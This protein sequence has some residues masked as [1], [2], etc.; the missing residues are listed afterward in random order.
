VNL[1]SFVYKLKI[2]L[3]FSIIFLIGSSRLDASSENLES[4]AGNPQKQKATEE[5]FS[6]SLNP[7]KQSP[8][9]DSEYIAAISLLK[10][11]QYHEA[12]PLL[13]KALQKS[14]ANIF[15]KADYLLCLVWTGSYEKASLF[16]LQNEKEL[17]GVNYVP[18]HV[19]RVFFETAQYTKAKRLYEEALRTNPSDVEAL[20]GLIFSSC[21]LRE[22]DQ[23]HALIENHSKQK[24]IPPDTASFL[25]AYTLQQEGKN[26]EAYALYAQLFLAV[27]DEGLLK[28]IQDRRK[29]ITSSLTV[30]QVQTLAQKYR[31][32]FLLTKLLLMDQGRYKKALEDLPAELQL[33]P[34]GF[35]LEV[36]WTFFKVKRYDEAIRVYQFILGKMPSSCLARIGLTYPLG[37]AGKIPEGHGILAKVFQE[38]CFETD[39]LFAKA[40]LLEKERRLLEAMEVYD[41]ILKMRP[42]NIEALKL[43]ILNVATLGATSPA[44]QESLRYGIK[45][46]LLLEFMDGNSAVDQLRWDKPEEAGKILERQMQED[47]DNL[48]ARYDYIIALRKKDRMR[49]VIDQYEKLKIQDP[50]PPYW[51]TATVADAYLYLEKP[52][53]AIDYYKISLKEQIEFYP[54]WGLFSTYQELRDWKNAEKTLQELEKFLKQ[55]KPSK[56]EKV[57]DVP[58]QGWFLTYEDKLREVLDYYEFA[59]KYLETKGW[60]LI[61]KDQLKE[62]E[63]YFTS[64]I[65]KGG[66]SSDFRN[67]LAHVHL[68]RGRPRL[69]LEEFKIIENTDPPYL[70]A[71]NGKVLALNT[72][73]Y[74]KEARDLSRKLLLNYPTDKHVQNTFDTLQVEDMNHFYTEAGFMIED[75]GAEEYWAKARLTEPLSPLFRIFQEILWQQASDAEGRFNWNRAGLGCEWIVAPPLVWKQAVTFDYQ[76][77]RDWGYYTTLQWRPTD[78]LQITLGY[79]SFSTHIPIRARTEGIE[80]QNAFGDVYYHESDLRDYGF[81]VGS[82]WYSDG[83]QNP[84]LK[85]FLTQNVLNKPDFKIRVGAEF[86]YGTYQKRDVAY[87]SPSDEFSLMATGSFH[88]THYAMHNKLFRSSLYSRLGTYK[89]SGNGFYPIGGLT[90]EQTIETSKTFSL[91]WSISWDH[92]VYDGDSTSVWR[93]LVSFRKSF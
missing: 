30:E 81:T 82:T 56:W 20:K 8:E 64:Y 85:T 28:E 23:A 66:R 59:F 76:R 51:V 73:N 92:K 36:A 34:F 57:E 91:L 55:Q 25:Y 32:D 27:Y 2:L 37:A 12:I 15:L 72:L 86:Y 48:R 58:T 38:K 18:K 71:Q 44:Q 74:K 21:R 42:Q 52:K 46:K 93:G 26:P 83:N 3:L 33:L 80:G 43:R 89:Q 63:K 53:T 11:G 6:P 5:S 39:A 79:D 84:Y 75:R 24:M 1:R 17:A 88:W 70:A 10:K 49:E 22:Y 54:L 31:E 41:A 13:Q 65:E 4:I 67:G 29:E 90:Y 61:Y 47:P 45:D 60:F 40:F 35:Q 77:W 62:A 9:E 14:P 50:N 68:W 87:F 78:P 16:Y 19:A 69:A 7:Q